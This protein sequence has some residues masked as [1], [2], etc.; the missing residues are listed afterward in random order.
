MAGKG[1]V[2][3]EVVVALVLVLEVVGDMVA[4]NLRMTLDREEARL[5]PPCREAA[6]IEELG[7]TIPP[8]P[9]PAALLALPA[10]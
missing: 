5:T 8:P 9:P 2:V 7:T 4:E 10:L 6:G 3:K 1:E